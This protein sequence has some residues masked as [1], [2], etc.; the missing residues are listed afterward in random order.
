MKIVKIILLSFLLI[1]LS[2]CL[3]F[4]FWEV[5]IMFNE[6]SDHKG[7]IF[8]TYSGV[9]SDSDSLDTREEDFN[10]VLESYCDDDILMDQ[11]K[12]GVYVKE[13]KL[14]EQD[15]KLN[16]TYSGIF[17]GFDPGPDIEKIN[18]EYVIEFT[19]KNMVLVKTNGETEKIEDGFIIKWSLTQKEL[20]FKVQNKN[21]EKRNSLLPF[22]KKWV[23]QKDVDKN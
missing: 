14:Y 8:I 10:E 20:Y 13:R 4:D 7:K 18:N 19:D 15:G 5:R 2:G 1:F 9:A 6:D 12:E 22:Y 16:F 21:D 3:T 17:S 23:A 11:V